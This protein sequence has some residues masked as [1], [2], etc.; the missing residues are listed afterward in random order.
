MNTKPTLG[1]MV[2]DPCGVGPE[3]SVK[4]LVAAEAQDLPAHV[5]LIGSAAAVQDALSRSGADHW[6]CRVVSNPAQMDFEAGVLE[7]LDPGTLAESDIRLG[8]V[9]AACGEAVFEW[10]R[11][12]ER[13]SSESVLRGWIMAPISAEAL[14]AA[15]VADSIDDL[16]PPESFLFRISGNLRVIALSEHIPLRS[17]PEDVTKERIV[18]LLSL[19]DSQARE[20]GLD[21]LRYAVAGL[22]PHA[23]GDEEEAQIAPAVAEARSRGFDIHGPF[24]P[25]SIFRRCV[26]G[27]FD[28]VV[29]MY[30][31]QG[32]IALKTAAFVG[33]CTIYVGAPHLRLTVPHGTALDI[34]GRGIARHESILTAVRTA[35]NLSARRG[36]PAGLAAGRSGGP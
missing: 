5:L 19:F 6:R 14:R 13:L 23:Y 1:L 9:S 28:V 34:A 32:Q 21:R 27:Q 26:E 22:N 20:W 4:A 36:F 35:A 11:L 7:I 33:A 17:V 12:A 30:H 2:G 25:D 31:D 16:Q 24:P 8:E 15:G 29:S 10:A 18:T 3:V